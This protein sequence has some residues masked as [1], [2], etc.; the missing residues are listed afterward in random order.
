MLSAMGSSAFFA[1]VSLRVKPNRAC[2]GTVETL[3]Q[4]TQQFYASEAS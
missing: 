1:Q 2:V 4:S 3:L